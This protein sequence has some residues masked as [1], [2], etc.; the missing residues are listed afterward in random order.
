MRLSERGA[1]VVGAE[2]EVRLVMA[3]LED[4][5][6]LLPGARVSGQSANAALR[7]SSVDGKRVISFGDLGDRA[8]LGS[9]FKRVLWN[10]LK[11]LHR[12]AIKL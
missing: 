2:Q 5:H 12:C 7:I 9:V 10:R 3:L 4:V 8:H 1:L 11:L 6:D